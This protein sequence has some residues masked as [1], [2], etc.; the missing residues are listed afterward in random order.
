[1]RNRSC[2]AQGTHLLACHKGM[3]ALHSQGNVLQPAGTMFAASQARI[4]RLWAKLE[5]HGS[6]H[7]GHTAVGSLSSYT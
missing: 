2:Q 5:K 7:V 4:T 3:C 6:A 1:M